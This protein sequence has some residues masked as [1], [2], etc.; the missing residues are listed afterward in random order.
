M[1]KPQRREG[2]LESSNKVRR[3]AWPPCGGDGGAHV[4]SVARHPAAHAVQ[5]LQSRLGLLYPALLMLQSLIILAGCVTVCAVK[6]GLLPLR[7]RR[8]RNG[9]LAAV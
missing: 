5:A 1:P 3:H 4:W 8:T 6:Q 9:H 2:L 7:L